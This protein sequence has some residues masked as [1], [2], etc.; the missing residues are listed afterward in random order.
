MLAQI[1]AEDGELLPGYESKQDFLSKKVE[2]KKIENPDV[3]EISLVLNKVCSGKVI[4]QAGAQVKQLQESHQVNI[5]IYPPTLEVSQEELG[6][7]LQQCKIKGEKDGL[8]AAAGSIFQLFLD[9]MAEKKDEVEN[10]N[11]VLFGKY[12]KLLEAGTTVTTLMVPLTSLEAVEGE[13]ELKTALEATGV[14][15]SVLSQEK[16]GKHFCLVFT[17]TPAQIRDAVEA[18][19]TGLPE[20]TWYQPRPM[21]KKRKNF[22]KKTTKNN[23]GDNNKKYKRGKKP[24]GE[25]GG[26][27]PPPEFKHGKAARRRPSE[28]AEPAWTPS[29]GGG[30]GGYDAWAPPAP[31]SRAPPQSNW[32][33]FFD[34]A[35]EQYFRN[36]LTGECHY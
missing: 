27:K 31:R 19:V 22:T 5:S 17:G 13:G 14:S 15:M 9:L 25:K 8:F 33:P 21:I 12:G 18:T 2:Q 23:N 11:T 6:S 34:Q 10:L 30:Y 3:M 4:G 29:F 32:Q 35:G 7:N 36:V 28:W 20:E 24:K 16:I 26:P 1:T